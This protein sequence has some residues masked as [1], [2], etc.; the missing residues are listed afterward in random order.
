M[1]KKKMKRTGK[2]IWALV[3]TLIL[4]L[5][6]SGTIDG[7]GGNM[8]AAATETPDSS[9]K[10]Q[11][12]AP[13]VSENT[14][15]HSDEK[16]EAAAKT[17]EIITTAGKEHSL[18]YE[19]NEYTVTLTYGDDA[20]IPEGTVLKAPEVGQE[21]ETYWEQYNKLL[22]AAG[23]ELSGDPIEGT[24]TPMDHYAKKM[25]N[26]VPEAHFFQLSL[27]DHGKA[28]SPKDKVSVEIRYRDSDVMKNSS[29][30]S[31]FTMTPTG[32]VLT[33]TKTSGADNQRIVFFGA[34]STGMMGYYASVLPKPLSKTISL[35][36]QKAR[37]RIRRSLMENGLEGGPDTSKT[38]TDN[39]DGTYKIRLDVR[40][41][42]DTVTNVKKANVIVVFDSS[43]SM[44]EGQYGHNTPSYKQSRMY[45]AK[46][47]VQQMTNSLLGKNNSA[48]PDLV[49][50][51]L[52]NF[53]NQASVVVGPTTSSTAIQNGLERLTPGGGTN[54]E[55]GLQKINTVPFIHDGDQNYV[56]FV[57]DGNPTFRKSRGDYDPIDVDYTYNYQYGIWGTGSDTNPVTVQ[58]CYDHAKDDAE[59]LV[60]GGM[61]FYTIGAFGSVDRMEGLTAYAYGNENDHSLASGRYFKA[62]DPNS[63]TKA[64]DGIANAISKDLAYSDVTVADGISAMTSVSVP[65]SA[66]YIPDSVRYYRQTEGQQRE[67]WTDTVK[68]H[69][70]E[71]AF[72]N[73]QVSWQPS[74]AETGGTLA[75]KTTYSV[76]FNVWPKQSAYD[77]IA[78]LNNGTKTYDTLTDDE[79]AVVIKAEDGSYSVKTNTHLTTQFT[80]NNTTST[81]THEPGNAAMKLASSQLSLTK[82]WANHL[83]SVSEQHITLH[84]VKDGDSSHPYLVKELSGTP[85][86]DWDGG[87]FY[88]SPGVIRSDSGEA[89]G[90][91]ILEKGHD[92]TLEETGAENW[93]LDADTYHPMVIDGK[94]T[95]LRKT[96]SQG[97]YSID[98][99]QYSKVEPEGGIYTLK[100]TNNRKS[101]LHITKEIVDADHRVISDE[102]PNSDVGFGYTVAMDDADPQTS[103]LS[104]RVLDRNNR[105]VTAQSVTGVTPTAETDAN[106]APTGYY[107]VPDGSTLHF[108]IKAG[109]VID[110]RNVTSTT[111]YTVTESAGMPD[112]YSYDKATVSSVIG[113][114]GSPGAADTSAV[115]TDTERK[116]EGT[117]AGPNK[118]FTVRYQNMFKAGDV[119]VSKRVTGNMGDHKRAFSFNINLKKGD[120]SPFD[121]QLTYTD[122]RLDTTG[123]VA[124]TAGTLSFVNGQAAVTLKDNQKISISNLPYGYHYTVTEDDYSKDGYQTT[125]NGQQGL[126]AEGDIAARD[127]KNDFVNDRQVAVPT[128]EKDIRTPFI[129]LGIVVILSGIWFAVEKRKRLHQTRYGE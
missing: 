33:D 128:S 126:T 59:A 78:D 124:P 110:Y 41:T 103:E 66:S 51:A 18:R 129:F 54:W 50:M 42:V 39:G 85:L 19:G 26:E 22:S 72:A 10:G 16:S 97:D 70:A 32:Y 77:L 109:W 36:L 67:N 44:K 107:N 3:L 118:T 92:Y 115:V 90:Y 43:G 69:S 104:F 80:K 52:V 106:H 9:G 63:L 68:N 93:E 96:D 30:I 13:S 35:D 84:V 47:A 113:T 86:I 40:G 4:A 24:D 108:N 123:N 57:S 37:L 89:N 56:I 21:S 64:L 53:D 60:V 100:A 79:K 1:E 46:R 102:I 94:L 114:G 88:I 23:I 12:A 28:V 27:E 81:E 61:E 121:G 49:Q 119:S 34:A 45:Y 38:V 98:G 105:D 122:T 55:D 116:V 125:V 11:G 75:D 65:S 2:K 8:V 112:G 20:A 117:I 120:G 48:T 111:R 91:R 14:G 83:D 82:K 25:I 99:K 62:D 17:G 74:K 101:Y 127:V 73:N 87:T 31:A 95:L 76:E 5:S 58:R 71:A 15:T 7:A 6:L 29:R